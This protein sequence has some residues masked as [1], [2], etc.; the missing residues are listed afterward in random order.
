[1]ASHKYIKREWKNG[2]WRYY[3]Y[4]PGRQQAR[5][6]QN[7]PKH[8][9]SYDLTKITSSKSKLLDLD[10]NVVRSHT[11]KGSLDLLVDMG[12]K[13]T[14]EGYSKDLFGRKITVTDTTAA[15]TKTKTTYVPGQTD[16]LADIG[17]A[18][19]EKVKAANKK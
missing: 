9:V 2:R 14:Q 15:G 19:L 5:Q 16:R 13:W 10:G 7:K 12:K 3:Y 18:W 1:M 4:N 6:N 11:T 17:K 8:T